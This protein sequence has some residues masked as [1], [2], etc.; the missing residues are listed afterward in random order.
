MAVLF[1][2]VLYPH[3][4]RRGRGSWVI[5]WWYGVFVWIVNPVGA[6]FAHF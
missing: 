4:S 3:G 6:I 1:V 5:G 2:E